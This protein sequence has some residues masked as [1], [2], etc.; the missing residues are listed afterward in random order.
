MANTVKVEMQDAITK[1]LQKYQDYLSWARFYPDL[2]ADF[3]KSKDPNAMSLDLHF[4]QRVFM[5]ADARFRSFSGNFSRG[6]GKSMLEILCDMLTCT[7][8]PNIVVYLSAQTKESAVRILRSKVN[9]ILRYYPLLE[10]EIEKMQFSKNDGEVTFKNHSTYKVIANSQSSKGLRG[11]RIRLEESA[12]CDQFTFVD[13][14]EPIVEVGRM[15]TGKARITN[16]EELN[17]Q[18]HFFTT[19]SYRNTDEFT[20]VVGLVKGMVECDGSLAMGASFY[21]PCWYGRGR[22]LKAILKIADNTPPAQFQQNYMS[23]WVGSANSALVSMTKLLRC[24]NLPEPLLNVED[25]DES[26]IY[27]AVDVARSQNEANN[28]SSITIGRVIRNQSGRVANIELVN[29]FNVSNTLNFTDQALIVKKTKQRYNA[30]VVVVDANGLGIGLVDEL[31]KTT[32]DP[33]TGETYPCWDTINT[34]N[35]PENESEAIQCVFDMKAQTAQTK[36]I[37]DFI[38]VVD[39]GMLRLLENNQYD[40]TESMLNDNYFDE[41]MAYVQTDLLV[42]EIANLQ[43]ETNG[44]NLTVKR[45]SNRVDKDRFSSL[46]YLVYYILEYENSTI[47]QSYDFEDI[48]TFRAPEIR[49]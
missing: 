1:N 8:Y 45:L 7:L 17:S 5:R 16:P 21:L 26:E 20:R 49:R 44:R 29:V 24:R 32:T 30:R 43:L 33:L 48:F 46:A 47:Q 14:M 4:D 38:N 27:M 11:H 2:Y 40:I 42:D 35:E 3:F 12:Q 22:S 25:G 34:T 10:N 36:I 15:L 18:I 39:S 19:T 37:S 41:R 9:E 23:T 31:L 6:Y 28:K 13:A